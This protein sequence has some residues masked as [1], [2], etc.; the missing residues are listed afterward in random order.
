MVRVRVA[1]PGCA[2]ARCKVAVL[3][4]DDQSFAEVPAQPPASSELVALAAIPGLPSL[5]R[6]EM[7]A[8]GE[9]ELGLRPGEVYL[10]EVQHADPAP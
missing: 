8:S 7:V 6:V 9:L 4:Y 10:V 3:G 5:R 2:D 1:L